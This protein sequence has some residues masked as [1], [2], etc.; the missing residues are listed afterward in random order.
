MLSVGNTPLMK[1]RILARKADS[2]CFAMPKYQDRVERAS[3]DSDPDTS[4]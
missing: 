2:L 1:E 3:K 4:R